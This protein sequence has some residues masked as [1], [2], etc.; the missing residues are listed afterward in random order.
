MKDSTFI[1]RVILKNY[2]SIAACD[3]QLGPLTF[4]VGRNGTGK[5]NFLDAL[6][7]VS[8]ALNTSLEHAIRDRGGINDVHRRSCEPPTHF[9]VR[10]EFV[11]PDGSTGHY[12][13]RIGTRSPGGYEV[14]T[15]E[16]KI[17]NEGEVY[18]RVDNGT[19]TDSSVEVAPAATTERLYLVNASGLPEFRP[20][21]DALSRM[22]FYNLNPD[23]IRDLQTPDSRDVLAR[24]GSNF[25]SV[26]NRLPPIVKQSIE[27]YLTIVVPG[28]SSVEVE[29][30]GP[31]EMLVFRQDVGEGKPPLRFFAK[32]MADSAFRILGIMVA[33]F[34]T[35][36]E[37]PGHLS[38]VGIEEPGSGIHPM[39]V[40]TLLPELQHASQNLQVIV[41]THSAA[42]LDEKR[43]DIETLLVA[44]VLDGGTV[45][46]PVD[47][48]SRSVVRKKLFTIGEL[49]R[50]DQLQPEPA[51]VVSAEEAK[52][53][54]FF[55]FERRNS[56][57]QSI[58]ESGDAS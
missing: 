14:Q 48:V 49:L 36:H 34:Q 4:I 25:T 35:N 31:K 11:L 15:E 38:L 21:Y 33:L 17:L 40:G 43:V 12:A 8:D 20:V 45:I 30:F 2:K 26:F 56:S 57:Q 24:D 19:V 42:L 27:E 46:A 50:C 41:P 53:L 37:T 22:G 29:K 9:S 1:T 58:R 23:K 54:R 51:S 3:V 5:S 18:F 32:N 16:C 13:F 39:V 10:L 55:N 44:E 52:Q 6:R 7:F 28:V 47:A